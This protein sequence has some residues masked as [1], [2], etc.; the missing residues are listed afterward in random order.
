MARR[1]RGAAGLN[2]GRERDPQHAAKQPGLGGDPT[3]EKGPY[4]DGTILVKIGGSILGSHDTTL[5]DLVSIQKEGV[6][7][8]VV[9]GGAKIITEWMERQGV[10]PRFVDGLRVTDKASLDIVVAVLTGLINK[11]IVASILALNGRAVGLSGV[12]GGMLRARVVEPE[13][14]LVGGAVEVDAGPIDAVIQAGFMPII[15]P[16]AVHS[17]G[18]SAESSPLLNVNADTAAGEIA[19]ALRADRLVFMTDVEGVVDSSHRLIPRLTE[20]QAR[21]LIRSKVVAGGMLPK[22]AACLSALGQV[23]ATDIIDGRRPH[24]LRDTVTGKRVGTRVG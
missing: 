6:Q 9:H 24:S 18:P 20:Q 16:V 19:V 3:P 22:I 8:V 4:S 17:G 10:R 14:G 15:A 5:E 21:G 1:A 2:G 12:D 7:P 13:L 11:S 23:P